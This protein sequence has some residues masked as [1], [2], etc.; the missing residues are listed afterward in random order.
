MVSEKLT[1]CGGKDRG[2]GRCFEA[3]MGGTSSTET[4]VGGGAQHDLLLLKQCPATDP[5]RRDAFRRLRD[6][7]LTR[8]TDAE[9][10]EA[11][12][13]LERS[14]RGDQWPQ[15]EEGA[16]SLSPEQ[17]ADRVRGCLF[18]LALGDAAG[19]ACEFLSG[20][21]AREFYGPHA[22]FSP[23]REVFPDEH[24]VMWVAGDWTD[25]TD[26]AVLML[27]SL[28]QSGGRAD[29]K[30][31][32]A[33]LR[34][35]HREGF[36]ELRDK[37]AAGLGQTTK[38][39]ISDKDFL[40]DPHGVAAR[41][42]SERPTNGAVMRTAVAGFPSFWDEE[43]VAENALGLCRT[44]HA[45]PLCLASCVAVSV[46]IARLLQGAD[47]DASM[48]IE[49]AVV[50]P[51]LD[52]ACKLLEAEKA[53]ELCKH[54]SSG[55]LDEL[56][57]DD[58]LVIGYT[59]KCLGAGLWAL[60][61]AEFQQAINELV[62]HGGDADTNGAVAGALLGC[63]LGFKR[64]PESWVDGLPYKSWLEAYVHKTLDMLGLPHGNVA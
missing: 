50:K 23:G 39:V 52:R 3:T 60:R 10:A 48:S 26:Q 58:P 13:S 57:L 18:G 9:L 17:V 53:D 35:W 29:P 6:Q 25:D 19:L 34:S 62:L 38:A 32:A 44:T 7:L 11:A 8:P 59:L 43:S 22:D 41:R 14:A 36:P 15:P 1:F 46:C 56:R 37:G 5:Q 12:A 33:R 2:S 63:R 61:K 47:M 49:E 21:Q 51:A 45:D 64:L 31:F 54:A 42:T 20:A 30:D 4:K 28:L 27:Q 55:T 24:R 40:R 16:S